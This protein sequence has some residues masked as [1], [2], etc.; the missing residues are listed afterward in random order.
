MSLVASCGPAAG[1]LEA[2]REGGGQ[3]GAD[4]Q[5]VSEAKATL[6]AEIG[7]PDEVQF[8]NLRISG[9]SVCGEFAQKGSDAPPAYDKFRYA[10]GSVMRRSD[11]ERHRDLLLKSG[12]S[13]DELKT[14]LA[15]FDRFW[16]ACQR[17]GKSV[18]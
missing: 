14:M 2:E 10:A 6:R 8:R 18:D 7:T 3:T 11:H 13:E 16:E 5:L 15:E 17:A 1:G 12:H 9:I 4:G